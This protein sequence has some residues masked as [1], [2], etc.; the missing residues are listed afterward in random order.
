MSTLCETPQ[1]SASNT[2]FDSLEQDIK[3]DNRNDEELQNKIISNL[4]AHINTLTKHINLL[5]QILER[6]Y[7]QCRQNEQANS[8]LF[9]ASSKCKRQSPDIMLELFKQLKIALELN[10]KSHEQLISTFIIKINSLKN[11]IALLQM[12]RE[13]QQKEKICNELFE[14]LSKY[15]R[16]DKKSLFL[17]TSSQS[18]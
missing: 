18:I 13:I 11:N 15:K 17:D 12:E 5:L 10:E 2:H 7:R 4:I 8:K 14:E 1:P 16:S 6:E 9:K 3:K